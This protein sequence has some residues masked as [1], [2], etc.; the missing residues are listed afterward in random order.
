[1]KI[2]VAGRLVPAV[3][4]MCAATIADAQPPAQSPP[5][6]AQTLTLAE[7]TARALERNTRYPYLA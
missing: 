6:A 1:M 3:A 2:G 7:A 4:V 5:P